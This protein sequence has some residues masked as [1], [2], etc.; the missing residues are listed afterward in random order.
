MSSTYFALSFAK[1][2]FASE[3]NQFPSGSQR[4]SQCCHLSSFVLR[5]L[6]GTP[7]D[8]DPPRWWLQ[9]IDFIHHLLLRCS[10]SSSSLWNKHRPPHRTWCTVGTCFARLSP[11]Q[12]GHSG[13]RLGSVPLSCGCCKRSWP[14]T[15]PDLSWS[16]LCQ[17]GIGAFWTWT[18]S[19]PHSSSYWTYQK[20]ISYLSK[21]HCPCAFPWRLSW[22]TQFETV[23][24]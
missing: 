19:C 6:E 22:L 12:S 14:H 21:H 15:L 5:P 11:S 2:A 18:P 9:D 16:P 23:V 13:G 7:K 24:L 10:E 4:L 3:C 1:S 8:P 17:P 20:H